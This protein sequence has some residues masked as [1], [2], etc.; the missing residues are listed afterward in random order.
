MLEQLK[1]LNEVFM[2]VLLPERLGPKYNILQ[3]HHFKL[4]YLMQFLLFLSVSAKA[5]SPYFMR[6]NNKL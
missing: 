1:L 3:F 6:K 4:V 5:A 2:S